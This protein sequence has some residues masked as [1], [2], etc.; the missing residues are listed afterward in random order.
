MTGLIAASATAWSFGRRSTTARV[1]SEFNDVLDVGLYLRSRSDGFVRAATALLD[2]G[3]S[4]NTG[5]FEENHRP[6]PAWEPVLYGAAGVAHHAGLT[7]LLL[8]RGAEAN[9]GEVVYHTPETYDNAAL[10]VLVESGKLNDDSLATLL[11]RK[12]DWHD[13][14]GIKYLLEHGADPNRTPH[15][16]LTALQQALRRDNDIKIIEIMLDHG[17]DPTL[18]NQWDSKSA[19]SM[20]ARRGRGDVLTLFERRGIAIALH[21]VGRLIAACAKN[22][23]AAARS[24]AARAP[25][26][27]HLSLSPFVPAW[28]RIGPKDARPSRS[29]RCSVPARR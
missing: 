8:A 12:A 27:T 17:A 1:T 4:A 13:D 21:G 16:R 9:D 29:R 18:A 23:A 26:D 20:A 10:K 11:L 3:A 15:W 19:V 22:D 7:R 6:Q 5:W 14:D 28:T 2:A 25:K 24:I